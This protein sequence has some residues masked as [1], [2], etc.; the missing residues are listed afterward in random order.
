[1]D[2]K[3]DNEIN[4]LLYH[5]KKSRLSP[6]V[7]IEVLFMEYDTYCKRFG[8]RINYFNEFIYAWLI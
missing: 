7:A 3:I 5:K 2:K 6:K 4:K 1:M 8:E